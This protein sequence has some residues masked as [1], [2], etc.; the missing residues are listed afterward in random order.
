MKH[1]ILEVQDVTSFLDAGKLSLFVANLPDHRRER[2]LSPKEPA[3]RA[4]RAAAEYALIRALRKAHI[5]YRE[6][7]LSYREDGKPVI[8][9]PTGLTVSFSHSA[10]LS[11][12]VLVVSDTHTDVGVDIERVRELPQHG[13][14]A[15]R[16]FYGDVLSLYEGA[17]EEKKEET[18]FLLFTKLEA[19]AKMSGEGLGKTLCKASFPLLS[20][21][22]SFLTRD[23]G[24]SPYYITVA[25]DE[26]TKENA[27][28]PTYSL[29]IHDTICYNMGVEYQK[30]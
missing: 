4:R 12:A 3:D 27:S 2:I 6:I 14:L 30:E 11:S 15:K 13:A 24:G 1:V 20:Q 9:Y 26:K 8:T 25:L 28:F 22:T 7:S 5:P 23:I 10:H 18:F 21:T 19:I 17:E 16:Y 29:A